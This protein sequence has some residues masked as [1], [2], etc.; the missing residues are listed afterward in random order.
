[1]HQIAVLS[2]PF[3]PAAAVFP[4]TVRLACAPSSCRGGP[5][6]LEQLVMVA[7]SCLRI[8]IRT[9]NTCSLQLLLDALETDNPAAPLAAVR[10]LLGPQMPSVF[11]QA[12]SAGNAL[13]L[14]LLLTRLPEHCCCLGLSA[15]EAALAEGHTAVAGTIRMLLLLRGPGEGFSVEAL[16]PKHN[17]AVARAARHGAL[18]AASSRGDVAALQQLLGLVGGG[19]AEAEGEQR[20]RSAASGMLLHSCTCKRMFSV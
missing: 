2:S 8:A 20:E 13:A 12:A 1:M 4:S 3:M 7:A 15:L 16:S 18:K 14:Q 6:L 17:A 10:P 5:K 11:D 9:H 19:G